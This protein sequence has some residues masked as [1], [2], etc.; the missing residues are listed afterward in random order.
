MA[1]KN[2][3]FQ[4]DRIKLEPGPIFWNRNLI[5]LGPAPTGTWTITLDPTFE[6]FTLLLGFTL[7]EP[8]SLMKGFRLLQLERIFLVFRVWTQ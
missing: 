4:L 3:Q 8:V 1:D 2:R 6:S 5:L 7:G